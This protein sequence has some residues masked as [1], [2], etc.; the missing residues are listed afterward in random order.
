[1][2]TIRISIVFTIVIQCLSGWAATT[3][4]PNYYEQGV[5]SVKSRAW[6][7]AIE[8]FSKAIELNPTNGLAFDFRGSANF[9]NGDLDE[10][11]SDCKEALRI[12]SADDCAAFN[13]AS[14]YRVKGEFEK[15]IRCWDAYMLL[16][17]TNDAAYKNR[18]TDYSVIGKYN[19][20]IKDWNEG[21][22]LNVNDSTSFAMRGFDYFKT[23]QFD[24]AEHDFIE[25]VRNNQTNSVALNNLA[26]FRATCPVASFRNGKEAVETAT[27]ACELGNWKRPESVDTLAA[28]YAETGNFE[29]AV[30]YENQ[31]MGMD[32]VGVSENDRENMQRYLLLYERQQPNREGKN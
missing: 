1:M 5:N 16:N 3:N 11:I 23:S 32:G 6:D 18:A 27:K 24:K 17:P 28:A 25:A 4:S 7:K 19:E 26:W 30:R 12:N 21:L 2:N 13:L 9:M 10:A 20:A 14:A 31:A 8:E 29:A 22:R 15:S